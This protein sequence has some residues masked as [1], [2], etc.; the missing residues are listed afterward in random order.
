MVYATSFI[1]IVQEIFYRRRKKGRM[2]FH[3]NI[4]FNDLPLLPPEADILTPPVMEKADV[5]GQVLAD[6]DR[7]ARDLGDCSFLMN[8]LVLL[9]AKDNSEIE[10]IF[11]SYEE[12]FLACALGPDGYS[13]AAC[14]VLRCYDA[15][16]EACKALKENAFISTELYVQIVR[17]IKGNQFGIR[18]MPGARIVDFAAGKVVYTP[19]EGE[20]VIR[21]KLKNLEDFI[22]ASDGMDP[23]IK[24]A[25]VHYQFE[26]IH[27]F[28]DGNGRTGRILNILFLLLHRLLDHPGLNPSRYIVQRDR[29]YYRLLNEVSEKGNWEPWILFMLTAVEV[30]AASS[31]EKITAIR[32]LLSETAMKAEGELPTGVF[33]KA[34]INAIFRQP[35]IPARFLVDEGIAPPGNAENYLLELERI[36]AVKSVKAKGETLWC[37]EKL[38]EM[39]AK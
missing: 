9:E 19:P 15:F 39:L 22:H 4:P 7:K 20:T 30:T 31:H 6:L 3:S 32:Q 1:T 26:A 10:N 2:A 13:P 14:E 37:N 38:L 25:L 34:L 16:W 27:P 23:L 24:M 5:A 36:G 33:S 21:E 18:R 12:A 35:Y 29:E 8:L 11:T 28:P 17:K